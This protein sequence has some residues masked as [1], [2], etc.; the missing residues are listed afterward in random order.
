MGGQ[1]N[2]G[3]GRPSG[4]ATSG[5]DNTGS[6]GAASGGDNTGGGGAGSGNAG[7]GGVS[8]GG[9][10]AE[11]TLRVFYVVP[12]DVTFD[13]RIPDGIAEVVLE[14]Q[15]YYK[16][17]L[18]VTF[19]V[20]DPIVEVVDGEQSANWYATNPIGGDSTWYVVEN[21]QAEL[22]RRFDLGEPDNRWKIVAEIS[23]EGDGG[24][25]NGWV[26]LTKHDADGAAGLRSEPMNRWYGGMV[27]EM[28][29]MFTLPDSSSTD[30]TP[31]SASFY[32][33]PDC[34]FSQSQK[35]TILNASQNSGFLN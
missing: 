30:G 31:M 25:G 1:A 3:G 8:Q 19:T 6:G 4:G 26:T 13:Q 16:E 18:G 5:G 29:H 15:R 12:T 34:H 23:S 10:P 7:S 11:K 14:A 32:D 35:N 28:G 27:H 21:M 9:P 20:N 22:K 17:E 33:Y 24:G 2:A